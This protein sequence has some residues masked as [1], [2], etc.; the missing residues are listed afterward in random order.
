MN[1]ATILGFRLPT[2]EH[3]A[4]SRLTKLWFVLLAANVIVVI[5]TYLFGGFGSL[6]APATQT[7]LLKAFDTV[8]FIFAANLTAIFTYWFALKD[9]KDTAL[10]NEMAFSISWWA[11]LLWGLIITTVHIFGGA[12]TYE[13]GLQTLSIH[14]NWLV[15]GAM[16]FYFA[17][18]KRL[19]KRLGPVAKAAVKTIPPES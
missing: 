17:G 3:E 18:G 11:S 4:R 14:S 7:A 5:G 8:F 15:S 6:R 12:A 2:T 9:Q 19:S 1:I 13:N 10:R 16:A